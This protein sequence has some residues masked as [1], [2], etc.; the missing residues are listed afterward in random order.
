MCIVWSK[1][2][3]KHT[4]SY[5]K[6]ITSFLRWINLNI[7][8]IQLYICMCRHDKANKIAPTNG[9]VFEWPPIRKGNQADRF[10][11][12]AICHRRCIELK[13]DIRQR[14]LPPSV[15][16]SFIT[17]HDLSYG[18]GSTKSASKLA[19]QWRPT[20]ALDTRGDICSTTVTITVNWLFQ[21]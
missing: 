14:C 6:S 13:C 18:E 2:V 3:K 21:R 19:C 4:D 5:G 8:H 15:C 16:R 10:F 7:C 20:F 9:L 11:L 17:Q 12:V 1:R